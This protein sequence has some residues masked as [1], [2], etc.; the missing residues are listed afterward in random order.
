[1]F[2]VNLFHDK[3]LPKK[4]IIIDNF[5]ILSFTL[6]C[7]FTKK[8]G[9]MKLQNDNIHNIAVMTSGGDSPGMNAAVRAVVRTAIYFGKKAFGIYNGYEGMIDGRIIELK[10]H[11][12]SDIINRGGTILKTARSKRFM[13][14]K[15][16]KQA[17][18]KLKEHNIDALVI[19]GGNGSFR[20]ANVFSHEYDISVV[21]IPGTIDNDLDGTDYTLGYDTA[22]NNVVDAVDKIRDTAS[23]F[24]RLFFVEVMGRDAG[25]IAL[26]SGIATGADSILVPEVHTDYDQFKNYLHDTYKHTKTSSIVLVAEGDDAGGAVVIANRIKGD[27]PDFNPRVSILGHIQRGGSPSA[28]DRILGSEMGVASVK[29]L[30]KGQSGVMMGKQCRDIVPVEFAIADKHNKELSK[31]LLEMIAILNV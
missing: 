18:E 20:G 15:Y 19:I 8:F 9:M 11:D 5:P 16:R 10:T 24:D 31:S 26:R 25:F 6:F 23:A 17:Y 28:F 4:K 13:E 30:L 22:L 3:T 2:A 29:A 21:G 27:F 14:T 1:M 7:T 12:V